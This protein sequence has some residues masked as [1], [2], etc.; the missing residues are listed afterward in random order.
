[1]YRKCSSH[2]TFSSTITG[3]IFWAYRFWIVKNRVNCHFKVWNLYLMLSPPFKLTILLFLALQLQ[4]YKAWMIEEKTWSDKISVTFQFLF[5]PKSTPPRL[6]FHGCSVGKES[7]FYWRPG[8]MPVVKIKHLPSPNFAAIS[9]IFPTISALLSSVACGRFMLWYLELLLFFSP[10]FLSF[11][12][13]SESYFFYVYSIFSIWWPEMFPKVP[14]K[15]DARVRARSRPCHLNSASLGDL[16]LIFF[17]NN[18]KAAIKPVTALIA[19]FY[20]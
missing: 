14:K 4:G 8:A 6:S 2:Y 12:W 20:C 5:L 10:R 7:C 18:N 17:A 9:L 13:F 19:L 3:H 11:W 15:Y 16:Q 1:M